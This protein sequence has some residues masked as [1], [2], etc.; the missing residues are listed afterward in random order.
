MSLTPLIGNIIPVSNLEIVRNNIAA[1]LGTELQNQVALVQAAIT[2]GGLTPE[3]KREFDAILRDIPSRIWLERFQ[4][5]EQF[6]DTYINVSLDTDPV[7]TLTGTAGDQAGEAIFHIEIG[8]GKKDLIRKTEGQPDEV[9]SGDVEGGFSVQR[10]YRMIRYILQSPN[11]PTLLSNNVGKKAMTQLLM[12]FPIEKESGINRRS[13]SVKLVVR[14]AENSG[15]INPISITG[16]DTL[17]RIFFDEEVGSYYFSA[18]I[19]AK[20]EDNK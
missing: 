14:I 3:Q 2:G 5:F 6:P 1:I 12:T 15:D 17:A 11:Y 19:V 10:L 20:E 4:P 16:Y 18:P 8:A 7:D 9:I 13:G